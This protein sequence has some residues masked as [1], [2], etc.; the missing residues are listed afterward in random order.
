MVEERERE[1]EDISVRLGGLGT[2]EDR[3]WFIAMSKRNSKAEEVLSRCSAASRE[4]FYK[5]E[6]GKERKGKRRRF[7][8]RDYAFQS[9]RTRERSEID[10]N[11]DQEL[12]NPRKL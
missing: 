8:R 9:E 6:Q 11:L 12:R 1:E 7:S 10:T 3:K 5:R 4:G 2:P